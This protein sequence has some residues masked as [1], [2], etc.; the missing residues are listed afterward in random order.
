M[1]APVVVRF[2]QSARRHRIGKARAMHVINTI[3]PEVVPADD[4]NRNRLLWI[5]Q[6]IAAW[7]WR[8]SPSSTP[9]TCW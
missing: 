6:T 2:T 5:G 8:S 3:E 4:T 9:T 7:I 1:N